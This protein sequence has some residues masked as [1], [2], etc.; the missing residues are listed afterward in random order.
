[1]NN[2]KHSPCVPFFIWFKFDHYR[3][4]EQIRFQCKK[5]GQNIE[6]ERHIRAQ[7][8]SFLLRFFPV[9]LYLLLPRDSLSTAL[10]QMLSFLPGL[11]IR[12][13]IL[14]PGVMLS[15]AFIINIILFVVLHCIRWKEIIPEPDEGCSE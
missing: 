8:I 13:M 12:L 7:R 1:M 2:C 11:V 10:H 6:P 5:C 14:F 4:G 3:D 9:F 15:A